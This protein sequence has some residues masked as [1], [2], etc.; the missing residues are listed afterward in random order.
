MGVWLG[1]RGGKRELVIYAPPA[2]G[3]FTAVP[4]KFDKSGYPLPAD[5]GANPT[6]NYGNANVA[7]SLENR[8]SADVGGYVNRTGILVSQ[9]VNLTGYTSVT[10]NYADFSTVHF[11]GRIYCY[12]STSNTDFDPDRDAYAIINQNSASPAVVDVSGMSGSCYVGLLFT[13]GGNYEC[14]TSANISGIT[15]SAV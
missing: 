2:S 3:V 10:F 12:V 6:A 14:E 8:Y 9:A 7:V 4:Y 15:A 1:P 5:E 13:T 11:N